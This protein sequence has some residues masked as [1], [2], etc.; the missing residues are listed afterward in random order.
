[1]NVK[2]HNE[3]IE[4]MAISMARC[5]GHAPLEP[6]RRWINGCEVDADEAWRLY[7]DEARMQYWANKAMERGLAAVEHA[8]PSK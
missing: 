7:L 3:I 1:M 4:R 2:Q 6:G 8:E 5:M